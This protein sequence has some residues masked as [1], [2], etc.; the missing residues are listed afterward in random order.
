MGVHNARHRVH[1]S[2]LPRGNKAEL[3]EDIA[4]QRFS[5]AYLAKLDPGGHP[6][7]VTGCYR[8]E[9]DAVMVCGRG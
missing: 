3:A 2:K 5:I 6:V 9:D 7:P 1:L 8:S 4:R